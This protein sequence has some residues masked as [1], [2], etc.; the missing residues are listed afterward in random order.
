MKSNRNSFVCSWPP[1]KTANM[2]IDGDVN[3]VCTEQRRPRPQERA[4]FRLPTRRGSRG[5]SDRSPLW[6]LHGAFHVSLWWVRSK[7]AAR[8]LVLFFLR[9]FHKDDVLLGET[10]ESYSQRHK[11]AI[12]FCWTFFRS[13]LPARQQRTAATRASFHEKE[14]V[15]QFQLYARHLDTVNGLRREPDTQ[16]RG[17]L[18]QQVR[19]AQTVTMRTAEALE[20]HR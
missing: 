1:V 11:T 3:Y 6:N 4:D 13:R 5:V 19:V 8:D 20:E 2:A 18:H 16:A 15:S 12:R 14:R 7:T 10:A 17:K 9:L